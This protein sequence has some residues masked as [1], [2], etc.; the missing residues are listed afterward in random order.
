MRKSI[1]VI[2]TV[3]M[4]AG[5]HS[6]PQQTALERL[7][8]AAGLEQ[9]Q[10]GCLAVELRSGKT[11]LEWDSRSLLRPASTQ[12][13]LTAA[14]VLE[15]F[16]AAHRLVT[17]FYYTGNISSGT[18]AGNLVAVGGGDPSTGDLIGLSDPGPP[19]FAPLLAALRDRG[20]RR[21]NGD[22]IGIDEL[23]DEQLRGAGWRRRNYSQSFGAPV[24]GLSYA[25]NAVTVFADASAG[26]SVQII[27]QPENSYLKTVNKMKLLPTDAP[28]SA[29]GIRLSRL[30]GGGIIVSGAVRAGRVL[31]WSCSVERPTLHYLQVL[32]TRLAQA[33]IAV[34]GRRIDLDPGRT[35]RMALPAGA[36]RLCRL[37]SPP[38]GELVR[39]LLKFSRN[40]YAEH[41]LKLLGTADRQRQGSYRSG[42]T[43]LGEFLVSRCGVAPDGFRLT[44]GSGLGRANRI[45]PQT[46]VQVLRRMALDATDSEQFVQALPVAGESGTLSGRMNGTAAAGRV[47]AKTGT[48][49]GVSCLAGYLTD[50]SGRELVFAVMVNG[51]ELPLERVNRLLD[52][53]CVALVKAGR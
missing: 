30:P 44:D 32:Q 26:K 21:I 17:P 42:S 37:A 8:A 47:R 6:T 3:M 51:F 16:G 52:R 48:M 9:A 25:R 23:F 49:P 31:E 1:L 15:K 7:R 28:R 29:A 50:D 46:L 41:F 10:I 2:F 12:K 40:N 5:C 53:F 11:L 43:A 35:N 39:R 24:N 20:V 27:L 13:L 33:G 34:T 14:A 18:L 19:P 4:L 22:L 38:L 36:Q 45:S